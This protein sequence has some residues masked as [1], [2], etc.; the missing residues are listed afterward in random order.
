M[1]QL[2]KKLSTQKRTAANIRSS[3][4]NG[5]ENEMSLPGLRIISVL[6]LT[7]DVLRRS[8]IERGMH[9]LDIECGGGDVSLSIA[10]LVGPSGLVV[11]ID[12]SPEAID[13]A[14]RR[15]TMA[16]YCYWMRFVAAYPDSFVPPERFDAI[17]A[18]LNR[19]GQGDRATF[20]RLSAFLRPGGVAV[21]R[22]SIR[23]CNASPHAFIRTVAPRA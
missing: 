11:G 19:F 23:S 13:L 14:E 10:K 18:R 16:G 5:F 8:G 6:D 21:C 9:V 22:A 15:A 4:S 7:E 12:R 3:E 2:A 20:H 1:R 17:V